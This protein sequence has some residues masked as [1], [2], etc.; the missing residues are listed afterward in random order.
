MDRNRQENLLIVHG[1]G[2]TA[3]LNASLFGAVTEAKK[4][5]QLAHIYAA[6]N[7]T[8]GLMKGDLIELE[9]IPE[10]KLKL[11]LKTPGSA[12][13]TSRDQLER[14]EYE[15]MA[16]I[17]SLTAETVRWTPAENSIRHARALDTMSG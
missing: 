13:G 1:G 3:V 11:L 12:I 5:P 17:L 16:G 6:R 2:P 15:K 4:Y 8:G 9:G 14:E 10:E 7:G